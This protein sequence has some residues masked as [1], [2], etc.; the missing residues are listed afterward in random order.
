MKS[1]GRYAA[2]RMFN[3]FM[4]LTVLLGSIGIVPT[5]SKAEGNEVTYLFKSSTLNPGTPEWHLIGPATGE[6][7]VPTVSMFDTLISVDAFQDGHARSFG[8]DVPATGTYIVKLQ[9]QLMDMGGISRVYVDN[10]PVGIFDFYDIADMAN[11]FESEVT[12]LAVMNLEAGMHELKLEAIGHTAGSWRRNLHP[13][14]FILEAVTDSVNVAGVSI[15]WDAPQLKIGTRAQLTAKTTLTDG[16]QPNL[17][18]AQ[19]S[20]QSGDTNVAVVDAQSGMLEATGSGSTTITA[21]VVYEGATYTGSLPITVQDAQPTQVKYLFKASTLNPGTPEWHLIGPATGEG[22]V[23]TVGMFDTLISI[24][25]FQDGHARSFGFD[26]PATGSY[27][28]QLQGQLMDLGGISRVY[29][30]GS[31]I[32]IFDFYDV[33]D[34]ANQF[35]SEVTSIAVM[36]LTAGMH[37]LKLEAIGHTAGSWRR[38]LHPTKFILEP[39]AGA[40]NVTG[41]S[42]QWS[43][44]ELNIG[45]RTQ[46]TAKTT[47]SDGSQPNLIGAEISY[48]SS[49]TAVAMIDA[50]SGLL[51]AKGLGAATITATVVY[52]GATYTGTL[53]V[54]VQAA[55]QK[56]LTYLFNKTNLVPGTENWHLIG[57]PLGVSPGVGMFDTLISIEAAADGQ[58]RSFGFYVPAAGTY[59]VNFQGQLMDIGGI[60]RLYIDG[61]AIGT[62]DF[63]DPADMA[64][65]FESA[66]TAIGAMDLE[67]GMHELKLEAIGHTAGSWRRNLHPTKFILDPVVGPLDIRELLIDWKDPELFIGTRTQLAP[68]IIL[69]NGTQAILAGI[70]VSYTSDDEAVAIVNPQSGKLEATG[71]GETM[72]RATMEYNGATYSASLPVE[73]HELTSV[74]TRSTLYTASKVQAARSNIENYDWAKSMKDSAVAQADVYMA[75]GLDFLWNLV[76]PQSLPR[77]VFVNQTLG[78]P[79]TGKE[80]DLFGVYPYTLD[81]INEP[82]KITDP[83]SGYKFPT[84]D[85]K[86]YYESGLNENGL[87]DRNLADPQFLVN[88]LYPEK[89]LTWGVDDGMGWIDENGN[90]FTFIAYYVHWMWGAYDGTGEMRKALNSLRDAYLYTGDTKYSRAGTVLLDRIADVYPSQDISVYGMTNYFNS[91]GFTGLGKAIGNMWEPFLTKDLMRAYDA[92]YPAMDDPLLIQFL[93]GKAQTYDLGP[94]KSSATGIRKN[95]ETGIVEQVYSGTKAAQMAGN[96]GVH[97]SALAM[98]AVVY[99]KLPETKEWLDFN[100][101]SGGLEWPPYYVSGGNM[102]VTFVNEV[103][104]DGAGNESSAAYNMLWLNSYLETADIL[105][106]YDGYS[107]ADLYENVKF[108]KMFSA[109]Y[110]LMLGERYTANIG[111]A[112][113]TGNPWL[114]F[115]QV[116]M[117]KAFEKYGDPIF[118][119][120]A[121]FLNDNSTAGIHGNIFSQNAEQI[122]DDIQAAIDEHGLLKLDSTNMTGFGFAAL[123]D[124]NNPADILGIRYPFQQLPIGTKSA[125]AVVSTKSGT[126]EFVPAAEGDSISFVLQVAAADSYEVLLKPARSIWYGGSGKYLVKL[127]GQSIREID[128]HGTRQDRESLGIFP[129]SAGTHT[130]E[131]I[132]T[133]KSPLSSSNKMALFELALLDGQAQTVRNGMGSNTLR[134]MWMYYGRNYA[135]GHADNLNLGLIAFGLDLS[136]D[137]GYPESTQATDTHNHEWV[138][139][140]ISHNTVVVDQTK[141]GEQWSGTPKQFD[142]GSMVKLIDV[143]GDDVYPQTE[144]YKRTSA[145]IHVDDANSYVVDFFRVKGGSEHHFSFHGAEGEVTVEG[146]NME[147]QATG[148]YAGPDVPFGTRI[149]DEHGGGSGY[150]GSGF[151]YLKNVERDTAPSSQ[152]SVDWAIKDTW[153]VLAQP[154]NIHLRLT[155]LNDVD[156]VALADGIPSRTEKG[157]PESLRYMVAKRSGTDL[158][159]TFTSV[160]EPYKDERF[161][162]SMSNLEVKAGG[163]VAADMDVRAVKVTLE[164]GRVDYIISALNPNITYTIA[165][166]LKFKGSFGVYSELNGQPVYSYVNEGTLIGQIS[167]TEINTNPGSISGTIVDF[168]KLLQ[169]DNEIIVDMDLQG[170]PATD[171]VNRT[172]YVQ[173]DGLRKAVYKITGITDQGN[174]RYALSIGDITLIRSYKDDHDFN[175]GFIYDIAAGAGFRIPLS[176]V[177]QEVQEPEVTI[178]AAPQNVQAQAGNGAVTLTWD[179][180]SPAAAG[181]VSYSVYWTQGAASAAPGDFSLWHSQAGITGQTHTVSGLMNGQTYTFAVKA[182]NTAGASAASAAVEAAPAAPPGGGGEEGGTGTPPPSPS[183]SSAP[184]AKG[185]SEGGFQDG[186]RL[187]LNGNA[188]DGKAGKV[189]VGT[190]NNK[191]VT[192]VTV[193]EAKLNGLLAGAAQGYTVSIEANNGSDIVAGELNARLLRTMAE[194]TAVLELKTEYGGYKLPAERINLVDLL[195]QLGAESGAALEDI[196]IRVEIANLGK[197]VSNAAPKLAEGLELLAP[198]VEFKVTATYKGKTVTIGTFND[199]VERMIVIPG[200]GDGSKAGKVTTGVVILNDGTALHVPTRIVS[201]DGTNQAYIKTMTNSIYTVIQNEKTFDDISKHWGRSAIEELASRLVIQGVDEKH[202]VPDKDIT[203]AEFVT[204]AVRALGL[205]EGTAAVKF[206]DV[207]PADWY[208]DAVSTAVSYGLLEGYADGTFKPGK[209]ITR[210]EAMV[211]VSRAMKIAHME[212]QLDPG[213]EEQLLSQFADSVE[214]SSWARESAAINMNYGIINGAYGTVRPQDSITRAETASVMQLLLQKSGLIT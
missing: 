71:I 87:F 207:K 199:Y 147:T 96:N 17:I 70:Q 183:P 10:N 92:F 198:L 115:D 41:V 15:Q 169:M 23:P 12:P 2:K 43:A 162:S 64:H 91:H 124:G 139:N 105:D 74:K 42:I 25:A 102:G 32:G 135:H 184:K 144:L 187:A 192:T 180:V 150:T 110:P 137:L 58:G 49:D 212:M 98:A 129:M 61:K 168:T 200:G 154:E 208:H 166:K 3:V 123:R 196:L 99:D 63:Y 28:V 145:M 179:A 133:G 22:A 121:Y 190:E 113:R 19:I 81:P 11:Q 46:L 164:N 167:S 170:H 132:H 175:K 112:S 191:K 45:T 66:V 73:V 206:S 120:L 97:Q 177:W 181:T 158:Q 142:D 126:L 26:V 8:F 128:F 119:Q 95:I 197:G 86:S 127:D 201:Q 83:S 100:F 60:S 85:F 93:Q 34:M 72:I 107:S 151:H 210:E 48:Q 131:F 211:I 57:P 14:K 149:S 182:V 202:F 104:R 173:N 186:I 52:E 205:R 136:P 114:A 13:T 148:S 155:M 82:W 134:D 194:K 9:G 30:D 88:E 118:A 171:L 130:I 67:A 29:V 101:A 51:E 39:A 140:T 36:N 161:I 27:F 50:Q 185:D 44:P 7:V 141:Q 153:K 76:P 117:L 122:A 203:R 209:R 204:I 159:S 94:F 33:A 176:Y 40:V 62:F 103:D 163:V 188:Q 69:N 77:S 89:G 21:T 172:I 56:L 165:D 53:P 37:E 125:D 146:L 84:N 24:D 193:D 111:D 16:T 1:R 18:G 157:N 79:I 65:Q 78:S 189:H 54:T 31:P 6:G 90:Y 143:E 47:L 38:N 75:K 35:E 68:K 116:Q 4:V 214:F 178:P 106:G 213:R 195:A 108:R 20:Y 138:R 174:G 156:E 5:S 152:Y 80:I 109:L 55:Q 59:H 160:I